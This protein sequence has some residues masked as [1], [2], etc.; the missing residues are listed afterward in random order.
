M[1]AMVVKVDDRYAILLG[2]DARY[3]AP[4]AFTLAHEL[5]H[6]MLNHLRDATALVDLKDPATVVNTDQQEKEA[7]LFALSLLTGRSEPIIT[8]SLA[9]FNAPTLASAV[10]KAAP[11]YK[12]EPGTLALCVAHGT[13]AWPMAMSA[14]KFIYN[15]PAPIWQNVN[16]F[17]NTQLEWD[18]IG[19]E[20]SEYLENVMGSRA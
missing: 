6:A 17:A 13:G 20:S 9:N 12:I 16:A 7:D 14:L 18:A 5:G 15:N 19:S 11:S 10:I 1:H 4:I 3:P 8:T 2:R